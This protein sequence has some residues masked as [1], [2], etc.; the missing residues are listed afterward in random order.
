M[1]TCTLTGFLSSLWGIT[2]PTIRTPSKYMP[3]VSEC[4]ISMVL[5]THNLPSKLLP[6]YPE[7][8]LF[9]GVALEFQYAPNGIHNLKT[10]L[11]LLKKDE[12]YNAFIQFEFNTTE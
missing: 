10:P 3:L 6:N 5:Y 11:P 12:R 8:G 4:L 2:L 7:N 1:K 9:A